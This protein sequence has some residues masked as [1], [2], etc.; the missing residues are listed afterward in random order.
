MNGIVLDSSPFI[1]LE[2]ATN[3][4][5]EDDLPWGA[6]KEPSRDG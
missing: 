6:V 4:F 1:R 5:L 3:Q 2:L